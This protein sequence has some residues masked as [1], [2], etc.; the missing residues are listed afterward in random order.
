MHPPVAQ[1]SGGAHRRGVGVGLR[2]QA[3]P[4]QSRSL[5]RVN[6]VVLGLAPVNRLHE[7]RVSQHAGHVLASPEVGQ[8]G[9]S[10]DPFDGDDT[11]SAIGGNDL[12]QG[13][14]AGVPVA[15]DYDLA[16]LV[17]HADVHASGVEIDPTGA[18]VPYGIESPEVSS[19]PGRFLPEPA[20]HRG[21]WRRRP[22]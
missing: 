6:A 21:L 13:V 8:P 16:V 9:L 14:L 4:A 5:V 20:S 1:G 18:L 19:S 10:E 15:M 22:Q 12:E 17:Q 2:E 11:I 7:A 3:A